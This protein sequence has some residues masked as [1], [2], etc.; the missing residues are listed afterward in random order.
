[1]PPA[2]ARLPAPA[3]RAC[4]DPARHSAPA[5]H[6]QAR[7]QQPLAVIARTHTRT[8]THAHTHTRTHTCTASSA[9]I[10]ISASTS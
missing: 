4:A 6:G 2:H 3:Q 9:Y 5:L 8:R 10:L 7:H 1:M